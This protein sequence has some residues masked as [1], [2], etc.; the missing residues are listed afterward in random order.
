[1]LNGVTNCLQLINDNW[2]TIIVIVGLVIGEVQRVKK[3][4]TKSKEEKI[5]SAKAQ[6]QKVILSICSDAEIE[7]EKYI[8]AGSIKRSQVISQIYERFPILSKVKNQE[9]LVQE[10]DQWIDESLGTVEKVVYGKEQA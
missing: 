6:A 8:K 1:M 4:L 9:E 2:L 10:I 5:A 7:W 3:Y